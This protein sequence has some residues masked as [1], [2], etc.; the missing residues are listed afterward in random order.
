MTGFKKLIVALAAL[1]LIAAACAGDDD[2]TPAD[3]GSDADAGVAVDDD[4]AA[5]TDADSEP[6]DADA[7]EPADDAAAEPAEPADEPAVEVE[8]DPMRDVRIA[9]VAH[10]V[11]AWDAFW[12]VVESGINDAKSALGVEVEIFGTDGWDPEQVAANIDQ[13]LATSPDAMMVTISDIDLFRE[14]LE[15][16][17]ASGIP[18]LAYNSGQGPVEDGVNYLTY[19]G[20]DE[21]VAGEIAGRRLSAAGGTTAVCINH[22]VGATNLDRR[23]DGLKAGFS[24]SVEV[25]GID[26]EDAS[27]AQ[28]TISDFYA[29]NPDVD[30][31][32]TLGPNGANPF[33]GFVEEEGLGAG[34]IAHAT[35][36]RTPEIEENIR[37]GLTL[38]ATDQQPYLQGFAAVQTL[39]NVLRYGILP[40]APVTSTGPGILTAADLGFEPDNSRPVR[41]A[42]V[43]H[44]V[45]AWDGFWCV[46]EQGVNTAADQ[47]GVEVE[48]FGTDAW[49]PEGVAAN[50]DQALA[51]GP[52]AMMVTISDIDL[53]RDPLERAVA[54]GIPVIAYNSGQGPVLDGVDYLTYLGQ[55]EYLGGYLGARRLIAAGG[56]TAVCINHA[57]GATN[58]DRRCAGLTD[59]F[60]EAGL[61]AEVL[62]VDG[63]DAGTSQTTIS[64]FF[65]ANPDV[66]T[67]LTL[68][69]NGAN[70]FYGFVD[71]EGLGADDIVHGTFDLTPEII[72]H[73][74]G[75]LTQFGIDQQPFL[76]GYG[77][78]TA[79]ALLLRQNIKPTTP[80]TPTGPGFVDSTNVDL[81]AALA[82]S[83]R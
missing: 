77:G 37:G 5:A 71:E 32:L 55:D 56:T 29:A 27:T 80:V 13:A 11:C 19:I 57:V 76:Q 10:A 45:C 20:Q 24:G 39:T 42:A 58:L 2:D 60:A 49:D 43:A 47:F 50:I 59:A 67:F 40:A 79:L 72:E 30:T 15:R 44:A 63:E 8:A 6:G 65:A 75:G 48:I 12:C 69:P 25:L 82:G 78:V 61:S 34:D 62:G 26:G 36:D 54:S 66:D 83:Y 22:A 3:T 68:G 9:A 38:F 31:F 52:D 28:T 35:F 16:A 51:T 64:D 46:V 70:P 7:A 74:R 53:F 33:Y 23:C 41:I 18:V 81:V 4:E 21:F 73:I 1:S 17:V 14:P